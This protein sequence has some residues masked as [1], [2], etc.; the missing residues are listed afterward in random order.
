M[1][2]QVPVQ[3]GRRRLVLVSQDDTQPAPDHEDRDSEAGT[4]SRVM[5]S[6]TGEDVGEELTAPEAPIRLLRRGR[7]DAFASL[8]HVELKRG[9]LPASSRFELSIHF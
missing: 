5:V 2:D 6:A 1:Q 9:I 8:D 7:Q 4:I 3:G